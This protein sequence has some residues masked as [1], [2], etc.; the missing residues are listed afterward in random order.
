LKNLVL[1][2]SLVILVSSLAYAQQPAVREFV[3]DSA[4]DYPEWRIN[5]S[6]I[7]PSPPADWPVDG[8]L[9]LELRASSTQRFDLRVYTPE[10]YSRVRLHPYPMAWIRAAI[11]VRTLS[12][13]PRTGGDM[14]AVGNRSR[15]GYFLG[16][17]GPFRPLRG[18]QAIEFAMQHPIG[19]PRLEIRSVRVSAE[20]VSDAVLETEPLVDEFGQSIRHESPRKIPSLAALKEAWKA[21]DAAPP[22]EGFDYCSYGGYAS[23]KAR[24]TGF[25]RVERIDGRWWFVDPDGHL[26]LSVGSDVITPM[27]VTPLSDREKLFQAVPPAEFQYK[28]RPE[29]GESGTSFYAWN[30]NRRFGDDWL[31]QWTAHTL[32]RMDKWGLNTVANWS[33]EALWEARKKPYV[34]PLQR[35]ETRVSWLGLPDVYSREFRKNAD[36]AAREQ[37]APRKSDPW[38]LGYFLA[39]EPPFPQKE[40]Q[41]V[42]LILEG[43]DTATRRRL[44]KWLAAGDTPERRK[45]FVDDAFDVYVQ[46]TSRAVRKYDRNHL[47]LGMRSGGSPTDAEIRVARAFDVY[48]VNIYD[49]EV[50]PERIKKISELTGKPVIIG[51]FHF[52]T[53]GGGLAASLVQVRDSAERG[54]AYRYYVENAFAMPELIGTHWFQWT[55]QP[56]TGRNDGE[57]YNIGFVDVTDRPYDDMIEAL[58]TTHRRLRA[59]HSGNEQPV[60]QRSRPN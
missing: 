52:G 46:V 55:D 13:P 51:E 25:F 32:H 4:A 45:K 47:N 21:E 10:G 50:A 2:A 59:I 42:Q 41:T 15:V 5:L 8:F 9:V 36:K 31:K 34:I 28:R 27:M 24:A 7:S 53:P 57:N 40:L 54:V 3:F 48:S 14:A 12:E 39:N 38:L 20:P 60:S 49:T 30:L 18:V 33:H 35:W 26:F 11:P 6:D 16:L 56:C 43:P 23:T 29:G 19:N 37:C 58:K 44:K 17:W 22:P 1:V